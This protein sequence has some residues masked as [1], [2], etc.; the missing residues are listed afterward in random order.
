MANKT[1]YPYGTG[2]SLPSSIGVINDL[3]TG[4]TTNALSAEQGVVLNSRFLNTFFENS[5]SANWQSGNISNGKIVTNYANRIL[6][7]S[8]S[9]LSSSVT[10][11]RV[12]RNTPPDSTYYLLLYTSSDGTNFTLVKNFNNVAGEANISISGKTNIL[13]SLY[14]QP[15]T[16]RA[17][18]EG[19]TITYESN[20]VKESGV[21][22]S[23]FESAKTVPGDELFQQMASDLWVKELTTANGGYYWEQGGINGNTGA[24]EANNN[25]IRT[26]WISVRKTDFA[27]LSQNP[28]T[29][30][31]FFIQLYDSTKARIGNVVK[32]GDISSSLRTISTNN[33]Y[34]RFVYYGGTAITPS[35]EQANQLVVSIT[36]KASDDGGG[37]GGGGETVKIYNNPVLRVDNPD[38]TVWDGEDGYFYL[39]ATG[40]LSSKRMYRSANLYEWEAFGDAP[41]NDTEALKVATAFGA[42]SLSQV[43]WAPHVYKIN[44]TTWNLYITKPSGGIAILTSHHPTRGYQYVK[45]I[46]K[47]V[48][49]GE[50]IDAEIGYDTDGKV[51][52]FT[53]GSGSI[54]RR[55]MT[56][57]G[58]DWAEN[59]SFEL[60]AGMAGTASGNTNREKTFEGPYLYRRKGYWYLFC[61]SGQYATGNYKLRVV[62]CQTLGG[63][64]VDKSG[65][66]ALDGYAETVLVSNSTTLTGP[67]HNAPIFVDSNN[68]TWILY[69]SHWSGFQSSSTRGVCLDKVEWDNDG[70]PFINDGKPS[71]SHEIPSYFR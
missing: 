47:P 23:V 40:N 66:S 42:S 4:G 43:M 33:G 61:S 54:Y 71:I 15:T 65:N 34:M 67:G 11:L 7:I 14:D 8:L 68:D 46:S 22:H 32:Y 70:W 35:N 5:S 58:L 20:F 59:S 57:D 44:P 10:S 18:S 62:R 21:S 3:Y 2:G 1:V 56:A 63:T 51:W 24:E 39:Y 49:A 60:C 12:V 9:G 48:N 28:I 6:N 53:G 37:G 17:Q 27:K 50:F 13:F 41:M 52:M 26:G 38:P 69:H 45:F 64:W 30:F 29:G 25:A 31:N 19:I 55:E 36:S 16:E